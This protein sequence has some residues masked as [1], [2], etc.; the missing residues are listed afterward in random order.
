[1]NIKKHLFFTAFLLCLTLVA[2]RVEAR[3]L[4]FH[5]GYSMIQVIDPQTDQITDI[6]LKGAV[7]D[8]AFSADKKFLYATGDRRYIHKIDTGSLRL[9]QTIQVEAQGWERFVFGFTVAA[10]GKTAYVHYFSRRHEKGEAIIGSPAVAQIDLSNGKVLRSIDVPWGVASLALV[11]GGTTLYAVGQDLY[12]IDLT[13]KEM[14]IVETHPLFEK[15]IDMLAFWHYTEENNG[16]WLSPYYTEEY[17]GLFSIDVKTGEFAANPIEGDPVF[18]YNAVYSP[19]GTKAFALMDDVSIID[20]KTYTYDKIVPIP[21]GTCYGGAFTT[22]GK[23]FYV[24]GGGSTIT[25]FDTATMV[26]LKII[27]MKTDGMG[28]RRLTF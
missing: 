3:D 13:K 7:R 21:E 8:T 20:L 24:G 11:K 26:P 28:L 16:V 14:S 2:G 12:A 19:D 1:M 10:D 17:M 27:Q 18:A 23:R 4:I 15:G 9:V 6:P 5:L 22:D 25:V